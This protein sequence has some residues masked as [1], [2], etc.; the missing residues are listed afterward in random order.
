MRTNFWLVVLLIAVVSIAGCSK[1]AEAM[2]DF[3]YDKSKVVIRVQSSYEEKDIEDVQLLG[4]EIGSLGGN[5]TIKTEDLVLKSALVKLGYEIS[6]YTT[7]YALI[8]VAGL[9]FTQNYAGS[10]GSAGTT[11]LRQEYDEGG[12]AF[13]VG[14]E[15]DLAQ[16]KGILIGYDV[17]WIHTSGEESD[18]YIAAIPDLISGLALKNN[19]KAKYNEVSGTILASKE[20]LLDTEEKEGVVDSV[21]PF[22]GYRASLVSVNL[23]SEL[24]IGCIGISNEAN[25]RSVSHN[26]VVGAGVK[27][28]DR[29]DVRLAG[30]FGEDL[31]GS[32]SVKYKF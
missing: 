29:V 15:G 27:I 6:E 17:R 31:G 26:A 12:L 32:A 1:P 22:V 4:L 5:I 19:V 20:I 9:S 10:L 25:F 23:D 24:D 8:G 3:V 28:N 16:A 30:V 21:T 14:I 11:L 18:D 2:E 7:P 13:G